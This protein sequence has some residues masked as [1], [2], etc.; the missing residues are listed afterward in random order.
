MIANTLCSRPDFGSSE[1]AVR[2]NSISSGLAEKDLDVFLNIDSPP[3]TLIVPKLDNV[4]E[5]KW[6]SFSLWISLMVYG[7]CLLVKLA[8]KL[9]F[10]GVVGVNLITMMESPESLMN[11]RQV[12]QHVAEAMARVFG[13]HVAVIFGSDD[14]CAAIGVLYNY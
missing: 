1:V 4:V 2:I 10:S 5:A 11:L 7:S 3:K 12:C 9:E 14:F 13:R 8:E 6:V